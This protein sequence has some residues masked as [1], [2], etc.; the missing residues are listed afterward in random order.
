MLAA[1]ALE[2]RSRTITTHGSR[3]AAPTSW[4]GAGPQPGP[5]AI[6]RCWASTG[7]RRAPPEA[8]GRGR[9]SPGSRSCST[10]SRGWA[11]SSST[12]ATRR[13]WPK[14]VRG[15]SW[16]AQ[17]RLVS[18]LRRIPGID[19][20]GAGRPAAAADRL[21]LLAAGRA[22]RLGARRRFDSGA[23]SRI[24]LHAC[25]ADARAA[26]GALGS[27]SASSGQV[28]PRRSRIAGAPAG[29]RT[30]RRSLSCPGTAFASFQV[31]PRHSR[32]EPGLARVGPRS[33]R[34]ARRLWRRRRT[35]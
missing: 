22:R 2:G 1:A 13:W 34:R 17:P 12:R 31:G 27:G 3:V 15:W 30:S 26:S 19:K 5:I 8:N 35:R 10:A 6:V 18:L 21:A 20:R 33:G 14:A 9:T 16:R 29:S 28:A 4:R 24:C 25:A 7:A 23:V 11:T 32:V